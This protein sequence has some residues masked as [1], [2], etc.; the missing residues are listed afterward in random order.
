MASGGRDPCTR[1]EGDGA[2]DLGKDLP[3]HRARAQRHPPAQL[4]EDFPPITAWRGEHSFMASQMSVPSA[5]GNDAGGV[6][7]GCSCRPAQPP[8]S[9]DERSAARPRDSPKPRRARRRARRT[10]CICRVGSSARAPGDSVRGCVAGSLAIAMSPL[11][12]WATNRLERQSDPAVAPAGRNEFVTK[13][14]AATDR[15]DRLQ[16][17]AGARLAS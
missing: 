17:L 15:L 3:R 10:I 13:P 11:R 12:S 14:I 6:A 4:S 1:S 9:R 8:R 7:R 16:V 5:S 2:P